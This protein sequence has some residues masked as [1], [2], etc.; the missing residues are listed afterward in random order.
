[1][2]FEDERWVKVYTRDEPEFACLSW[3]ARGLFFHL[4]RKVDRAGVLRCGRVGMRGVAVAIQAPWAEIE[5]FLKEL[6]DDG[7]VVFDADTGSL[8]VRNFVEAQG[9]KASGKARQRASREL[10]KATIENG[11]P[12]RGDGR[13]ISRLSGDAASHRADE[14]SPETYTVRREVTSADVG[15]RSDQNRIEQNRTDPPNPPGGGRSAVAQPAAKEGSEATA[16][17]LAPES[18][19]LSAAATRPDTPPPATPAAAAPPDR[20]PGVYG[21]DDL[22]TA[23]GAAGVPKHV[24]AMHRAFWSGLYAELVAKALGSTWLMP[25]GGDSALEDALGAHCVGSDRR[26]PGAWLTTLVPAFVAHAGR[27]GRPEVWSAYAPKGFVRWLN[28]GHHR[29]A[30]ERAKA[31]AL[32]DNFRPP[33]DLATPTPAH[34]PDDLV[35]ADEHRTFV[36]NLR[37]IG[38]TKGLVEAPRMRTV[39]EMAELRKIA[40]QKVARFEAEQKREASGE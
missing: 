38:V 18:D 37:S 30:I 16:R 2:N 9:A 31:K 6:F 21:P 27:E 12:P 5:P 3:Q 24:F 14:S 29:E 10:A 15:R 22:P 25:R 32:R 7:C 28:G 34:P 11:L 17:R 39:E 13:T 36:E 40:L 26:D 20:E 8:F 35:P 1:M 19:V 33:E 4:L 23:P